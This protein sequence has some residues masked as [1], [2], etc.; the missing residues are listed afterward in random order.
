[1]DAAFWV[2]ADWGDDTLG[3]ELVEG[4]ELAG[5][6]FV[7]VPEDPPGLPDLA[8]PPGCPDWPL[9]D[10]PVPPEALVGPELVEGGSSVII[11]PEAK[12]LFDKSKRLA[13]KMEVM[14]TRR[15]N[16]RAVA[17]SGIVK[18][19]IQIWAQYAPAPWAV[20]MERL[21]SR[22][23]LA[24]RRRE[25]GFNLLVAV[26]V[27]H[28]CAGISR[29]PGQPAPERV[30]LGVRPVPP[31]LQPDPPDVGAGSGRPGSRRRRGSREGTG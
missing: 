30:P 5:P 9:L 1:M 18:P 15:R 8:A 29:R 4:A 19:P 7:P 23:L 3:A 22:S 11:G 25:G 28:C 6:L 17:A 16:T 21:K 24:G 13:S 31:S 2:V 12:A 20:S 10:W 27:N 26:V 14:P